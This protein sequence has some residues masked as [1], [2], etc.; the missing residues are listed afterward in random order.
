MPHSDAIGHEQD[1]SPD[2]A[3]PTSADEIASHQAAAWAAFERGDFA[4]SAEAFVRLA[5]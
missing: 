3:D 5:R 1:G 4:A 2:A